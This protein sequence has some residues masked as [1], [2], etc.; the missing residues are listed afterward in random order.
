MEIVPGQVL[1]VASAAVGRSGSF[2]AHDATVVIMA[3]IRALRVR[4]AFILSSVFGMRKE[5]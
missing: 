2:E 3:T 4:R 5:I 1:Q